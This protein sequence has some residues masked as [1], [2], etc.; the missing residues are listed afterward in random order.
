M[1]IKFDHLLCKLDDGYE[2][3]ESSNEDDDD[4]NGEI[5]SRDTKK[6]KYYLLRI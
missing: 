5:T 2:R 6:G 4:D 1:L 3:S